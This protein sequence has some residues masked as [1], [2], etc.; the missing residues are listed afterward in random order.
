[1]MLVSKCQAVETEVRKTGIIANDIILEL[2]TDSP[3]NT[4][5]LYRK[6][7]E[8]LVQQTSFKNVH[9]SAAGVFRFDYSVLSLMTGA[10]T[11][12]FIIFLQFRTSPDIHCMKSNSTT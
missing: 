10:I 8:V 6:Q 7:L 1:M 5:D 11:S 2:Q 3:N 12:N 4:L 9:F